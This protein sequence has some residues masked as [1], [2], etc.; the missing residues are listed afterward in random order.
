M[1]VGKEPTI[2][3]T[4]NDRGALDRNRRDSAT[5][6]GH[7]T[8]R[9]QLPEVCVPDGKRPVHIRRTRQPNPD[10]HVPDR[11]PHLRGTTGISE[12]PNRRP[13][14]VWKLAYGGPV[15]FV[16]HWAGVFTGTPYRSASCWRLS[17]LSPVIFSITVVPPVVFDVS[18]VADWATNSG[19][20][21]RP[22]AHK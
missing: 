2:H 11:G 8:R 13:L 22:D 4:Q 15:P 9:Q 7:R 10:S 21:E 20:Q 19:H 14:P 3:E 12:R 5:T 6:G 16:A 1:F 17:H 18:C